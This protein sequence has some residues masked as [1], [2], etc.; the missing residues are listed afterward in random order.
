MRSLLATRTAR[1]ALTAFAAVAL[2]TAAAATA[3]AG[4]AAKQSAPRACVTKDLKLTTNFETQAG[5]YIRVTAKAR[6]GVTCRLDG[7]Y[8]S[9][10]FGSSASTAV[11]PAEQAVSDGI[12]LSGNKAAYAGINPKS[13]GDDNG[14]EFDRLHLS[15]Y[16]DEA[17]STTLK[18]SE[19]VTVDRPIATNWHADSADAVPFAN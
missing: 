1:L 16:G 19:S 18:L 5:G 4:T 7:V 10:S 15:V 13:T 12:T 8:P 14:I 17:N 2:T 11:H 6:A 3:D 9:A